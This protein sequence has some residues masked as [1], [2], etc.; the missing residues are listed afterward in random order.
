VSANLEEAIHWALLK[1]GPMDQFELL[2]ALSRDSTLGFVPLST[3]FLEAKV[4]NRL[5]LMMQAPYPDLYFGLNG[6]I[7]V[8]KRFKQKD[9]TVA[10]GLPY[11]QPWLQIGSGDESVYTIFSTSLMDSYCRAGLDKY[12]I[13]VGRTSRN[14]E[15]RL[16]ELQTGSHL[17]L[18][19]GIQMLTSNS[20]E[21]EAEIH[22]VLNRM[23]VTSRNL[24][25]EWFYTNMSEIRDIYQTKT[26]VARLVA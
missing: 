3:S 8:S 25:S 18:R 2:E 20:R 24:S 12:P 6:K 26:S 1:N 19:I 14:L 21:L 13:K 16:Q 10:T 15:Q 11:C 4:K 7:K 22:R 23:R 17:D 9:L 5:E